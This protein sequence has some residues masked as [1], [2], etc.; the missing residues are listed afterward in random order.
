M[1]IFFLGI[2]GKLIHEATYGKAIVQRSYN[3][4]SGPLGCGL[5]WWVHFWALED[6]ERDEFR[7]RYPK[8]FDYLG[9][10]IRKH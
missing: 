3:M 1:F 2:L 4:D 8:K 7:G 6:P 9:G 5:G 10:H